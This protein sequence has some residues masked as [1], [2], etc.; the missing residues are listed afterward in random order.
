MKGEGPYYN[1]IP[2]ICRAQIMWKIIAIKT[3]IRHLGGMKLIIAESMITIIVL[4]HAIMFL[5]VPLRGSQSGFGEL[6]DKMA[7]SPGKRQKSI[8]AGQELHNQLMASQKCWSTRKTSVTSVINVTEHQFVLLSRVRNVM[9]L[10]NWLLYNQLLCYYLQHLTSLFIYVF[11]YF[12]LC[13]YL[14]VIASYER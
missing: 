6:A 7:P 3:K 13:M 8:T 14:F 1:R 10:H 2:V 4:N 5:L 9:T 12:T 11:I